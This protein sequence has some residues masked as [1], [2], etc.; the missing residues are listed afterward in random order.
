MFD[1]YVS[2]SK[3]SPK[4][5]LFFYLNSPHFI[6]KFVKKWFCRIVQK[7]SENV[8]GFTNNYFKSQ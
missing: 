2:V 8:G 4:Y 1:L 5:K 6:K 7:T 3:K